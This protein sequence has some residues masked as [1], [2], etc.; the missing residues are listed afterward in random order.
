MFVVYISICSIAAYLGGVNGGWYKC[1]VVFFHSWSTHPQVF[2]GSQTQEWL[3]LHLLAPSHCF[4]D[5]SIPWRG[6]M[7]ES[8]QPTS[9]RHHSTGKETYISYR[10]FH[11][12]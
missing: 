4:M 3:Q 7:M 12:M 9:K 6:A 5:A 10:L 1:L 8:A 11:D 2:G